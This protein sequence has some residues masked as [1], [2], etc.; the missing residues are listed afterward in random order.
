MKRTRRAGTPEGGHVPVEE[1][2]SAVNAEGWLADGGEM[3]ELIRSLD[4]SKSA[5]GPL[6]SWPQSLR[7]A[8]GICLN[9]RFP[10]LIW[11]G[12]ELVKIYND[13][14]RQVLGSKHPRSMGAPGRDVWPEIWHIIGPML[15]G[16][17][18][19][20]IATWSD[21][22]LLMLERNGYP[23]ECYFTFSYSPIRDE[24]GG[25][26]G[27][28]S[29]VP[30]TTGR[31]L[32]ERRLR[33]LRE[34]AART[35]EAR[36]VRAACDGIA[37]AVRAAP[38]DM[39]VALLYLL[40]RDGATARL[41]CAAGVAPGSA[42]SPC[43]IPLA[44]ASEPGA[45]ARVEDVWQVARVVESGE[46]IA[47]SD[48]IERFGLLGDGP[49]ADA[50]HTAVVA[51]V[52]AAGQQ[53]LA[54]VL[55]LGVSPHRELD[56]AYRD[57]FGLVAG[58][59]A[60]ALANARSYEEERERIEAL[61]ELDRA[62]T[63]FFS[64]VSHEFRTPLTLSLAPVEDALSDVANPLPDVQ[65][66]RLEI[67]R[68]N[69]LR[70]LKLVNTL[71]DFSRIEAGRIQAAYEPTDLASYT[72]ELAGVFHSLIEHAGLRFTVNCPPLPEPVYV[73]RMMWENIVL[74]LLSNAF[75]FTF[76]GEI[77]V[78]LRVDSDRS[79]VLEVRDT[80]VGIPNDE[81]SRVFERYHRVQGQQ[82]RTYEGTGIGL[83][84]VQELV[85]LHGGH[86][87][88]TSVENGGSVFTV[89]IPMGSAHL[90]QARVARSTADVVGGSIAH[91]Y[92]EEAARWLPE[93]AEPVNVVVAGQSEVSE[94][95]T[96]TGARDAAAPQQ[97]GRIVLADDNADLRAYL[98]RILGSLYQVTAV[99]DGAAALTAARE[100]LPDLV[101][102][103]VMM[104]GLDGFALLRELRR[105]PRTRD[106]PVVLL[107]ARA[108]EEAT[109]EGLESGADDYLIKPFSARVVLA[110]VR[111]HLEL[112]RIRRELAQRASELEAANEQL[113]A[114][115]GI[116]TH[117]LRNPLAAIR[118]SVQL[119]DRQ[120][121]SATNAA[122]PGA[123]P[124][125]R[126]D[127]RPESQA[128][129]GELLK[130]VERQ[131]ARI[132][133]L[134]GDL[135]D[136]SRVATDKLAIDVRECD[137]SVIVRGVVEELR[138]TYPS[139]T[140]VFTQDHTAPVPVAA[141]ADRISQVV[142]NYITNAL[143][144]SAPDAPVT[145]SLSFDDRAAHVSVRDAGPGIPPGELKH[146]WDRFHRVPGI[147]A[148]SG[149][150]TSIGLG[151][152]ICRTLIERQGGTVAVESI[153]GQGS[154]FSF[155]L[156]LAK[157]APVR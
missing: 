34:L 122:A 146:V 95:V 39:P 124:P 12:P 19:D 70:L 59:V 37:T 155:T 100:S 150:G 113:E 88:A 61:A 151:L 66:E 4:W 56:D 147:E 138:M 129:I 134:V 116:V 9:S 30:E 112:G 84:L 52:P 67:V 93:G 23:E 40:D 11:W 90:P 99:A 82:S 97:Q 126:T 141:D 109:I 53:Q 18:R 3:G 107:S 8:V 117:E 89:R 135:L 45:I 102:S 128:R 5:I 75:K 6:D 48:L 68:R 47:V 60:T 119:A 77:T 144:Y 104:P 24:T 27:V 71:L 33:A 101:L 79:V 20:G 111:A 26:G 142:A 156:P 35:N 28:F 153:V 83:A 98:S 76:E 13:A 94:A 149:F 46:V 85:H 38:A 62:K 55:I 136:A 121:H 51:P 50:P 25:I 140:I 1:H 42:A 143:K 106:I 152:F 64:N 44:V 81:L 148:Q 86:I 15:E 72:A 78:S 127:M 108:G 54:G 69:N 29:A 65:R 123:E 32:S 118:A 110:R 133:R 132:D 7:T 73:D 43:T 74:N 137:L 57:F 114:F 2:T 115:L 41:A 154:T 91:A 10:I 22:Q 17:L 49:E 21:D 96:V 14:Y 125:G 139:R 16:V 131:A 31:V 105:D 87:T 130:R 80:G 36:T 103:D 157:S 92:V 120:L 145:V 58:N 63:A